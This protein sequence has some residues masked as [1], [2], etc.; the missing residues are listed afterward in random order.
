MAVGRSGT[1]LNINMIRKVI[2]FVIMGATLWISPLV[3]MATMTFIYAPLTTWTNTWPN[4]KIFNY[5]FMDEIRD[6][7]KIALAAGLMSAIVY[8][9]GLMF[10]WTQAGLTVPMRVLRLVVQTSGGV[11]AYGVLS[12]CFR[13][14]PLRE[15][16]RM[17]KPLIERR[18]PSFALRMNN[19]IYK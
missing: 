1:M 15:Y 14:D 12:L 10:I 5:T 7:A 6:V 2:G 13:L 9:I 4:K 3:F 8:L 18:L 11:L 17:V 16:F 19:L